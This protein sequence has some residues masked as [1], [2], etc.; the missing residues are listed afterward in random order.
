[1]NKKSPHI[2]LLL[3][4]TV[5]CLPLIA[6]EKQADTLTFIHIKKNKVSFFLYD[7]Y[8]NVGVNTAGIYYSNHFRKL[9]QRGGY[10]LGI[11]QY[12]PLKDKIFLSTG[13]NLNQRNFLVKEQI[14]ELEI[15]NLYL[16]L[17][18]SA[19]FE[20]PA[21][22]NLDLR[23]YL[24][25][26]LSMRLKSSL[27]DDFDQANPLNEFRYKLQDLHQ[28]DIGWHFGF[29]AEYKDVLFRLRSYSGFIK[30][31]KKDQG[32]LHSLNIEIGYFLFRNLKNKMN[33]K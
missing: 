12:L 20:L 23:I 15:N 10:I 3:I 22:R 4:A 25:T 13:F 7:T 31:D 17:P 21:M 32:M 14:K 33:A 5:I 30:Y 28:G 29:S 2:L 24:G 18:I 6:Q 9:N 26:T 11:E 16:D 8:V 1:M 27:T 19:A